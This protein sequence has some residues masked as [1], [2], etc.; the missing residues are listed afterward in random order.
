MSG[1]KAAVDRSDIRQVRQVRQGGTGAHDT[2]TEDTHSTRPGGGGGGDVRA[3]RACGVRCARPCGVRCARALRPPPASPE[4][5]SSKPT[6]ESASELVLRLR[7]RLCR[8]VTR[9]DDDRARAARGMSHIHMHHPLPPLHPRS[10]SAP[11]S[12]RA[13]SNAVLAQTPCSTTPCSIAQRA[14]HAPAHVT[15]ISPLPLSRPRAQTRQETRS[16][17]CQS[18]VRARRPTPRPEL[19]APIRSDER[20]HTTPHHMISTTHDI[21]SH[22]PKMTA[23]RMR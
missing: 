20:R 9:S 15:I 16:P 6:A 11:S 13:R 14:A 5:A 8:A 7:L 17:L 1:P 3:M 22:L 19:R 10:P 18:P 4:R 12:R 21:S 23:R 2:Q